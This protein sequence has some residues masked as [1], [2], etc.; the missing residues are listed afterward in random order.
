MEQTG[1]CGDLFSAHGHV[2]G[3]S[4]KVNREHLRFYTV[5]SGLKLRQHFA[6]SQQQKSQNC[7]LLSFPFPPSKNLGAK[8]KLWRWQKKEDLLLSS[9]KTRHRRKRT[10]PL[11]SLPKNP[12][13]TST[14]RNDR[15]IARSSQ[16]PRESR[17]FGV[18][19]VCVGERERKEEL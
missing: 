4:V 1:A 17:G 16:Q 9:S 6:S 10:P 5:Q 14:S 19:C 18:C 8:R 13:R 2:R 11:L 12:A 7:L 3:G 15:A